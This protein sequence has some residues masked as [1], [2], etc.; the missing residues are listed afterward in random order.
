MGFDPFTAWQQAVKDDHQ[1]GGVTGYDHEI[2]VGAKEVAGAFKGVVDAAKVYQQ[3]FEQGGVLGGTGAL[4]SQFS[5]IGDMILPGVGGAVMSAVGSIMSTVGGLFTQAARDI[6]NQIEKNTQNIMLQYSEKQL[7]LANTITQLQ[8]QE[9]QAISSLSGTKGGQDQLNKILPS[10]EQQISSLQQQAKDTM[11]T[12]QY[13]TE[14]LMLQNDTLSQI[15][16]EWEQIVQQVADYLSAG[17]SATTAS[18]RRY[19]ELTR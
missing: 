13:Q 9:M 1:D 17:G 16:Q 4:I 12:F 11:A 18:P 14:N 10:L 15:N 3:G 8:E 2:A 5:S 19:A 6:V 7:D